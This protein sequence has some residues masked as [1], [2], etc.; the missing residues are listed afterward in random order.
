[1]SEHGTPSRRVGSPVPNGQPSSTTASLITGRNR[2]ASTSKSLMS[3]K[4]NK[5]ASAIQVV[6]S[7]KINTAPRKSAPL[8]PPS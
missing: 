4:S 8:L 5:T 2:A 1:M 7:K 6:G 3:V